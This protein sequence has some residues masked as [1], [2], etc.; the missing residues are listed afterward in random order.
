ME[1]VF[2]ELLQKTRRIWN[3]LNTRSIV[4]C[5]Y[6]GEFD[7]YDEYD[8]YTVYHDTDEYWN[9]CIIHT[10]SELA[11]KKSLEEAIRY[12]KKSGTI[13]TCLEKC[14]EDLGDYTKQLQEQLLKESLRPPELGGSEY[15][16]SAE[17]FNKRVYTNSEN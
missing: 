16:K 12:I 4:A 11:R 9:W 2:I 13:R 10:T 3:K 8:Y 5:E 14:I 1:K 17:Q 7:H 15:A 6:I